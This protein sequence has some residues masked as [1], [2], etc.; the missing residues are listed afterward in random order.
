MI[1][2]LALLHLNEISLDEAY[3][4]LDNTIDQVHSGEIDPEWWNELQLSKYE[5]TA[6]V[7][8][9]SLM[10]LVRLRYNGWPTICNRCGLAL[11]YRVFGLW[12]MRIR[13]YYVIP[14]VHLFHYNNSKN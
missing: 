8:G 9:A 7:Q 5:V 12:R 14:S 11:D 10:N 2:L 3:D 6:R 13:L 1:D 4:M